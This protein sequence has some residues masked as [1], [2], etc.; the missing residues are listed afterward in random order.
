MFRNVRGGLGFRLVMATATAAILAGCGADTASVPTPSGSAASPTASIAPTSHTP[1]PAPVSHLTVAGAMSGDVVNIKAVCGKQQIIGNGADAKYRK[2]QSVTGSL[3]G[4]AFLANIFDPAGYGAYE[5]HTYVFVRVT[6]PTSDFYTWLTQA[7]NGVS[8]FS[9]S[10][11][12]SVAANVPAKT[13]A[14]TQVG[15]LSPKGPIT[16]TGAVIC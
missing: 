7:K 1:S 12:V 9:S 3:N 8:D 2:Y 13:N 6:P 5:F 15:G 4:A 10:R 16:L 11:G 14:D